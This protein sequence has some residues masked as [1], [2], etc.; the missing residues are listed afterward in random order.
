MQGGII[1]FNLVIGIMIMFAAFGV[2]PVRERKFGVKTLQKCSGVPL[3]ILWL[4]E[5]VWDILNCI[6]SIILI[7]LVFL[8]GYQV[9]G[10]KTFVENLDC[11]IGKRYLIPRQLWSILRELYLGRSKMQGS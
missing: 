8:C 1:T 11:F 7:L 9:E 6:P 10:I 4:A 3:W 5:Y 2:L